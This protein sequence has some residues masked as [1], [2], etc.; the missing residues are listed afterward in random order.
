MAADAFS[1]RRP[2]A[3]LWDVFVAVVATWA[4]YHVPLVLLPDFVPP[5]QVRALEG[6]ITVVFGADLVVQ[7]AR[8]RKSGM[9]SVRDGL[10]LAADAL[11]AIPFTLLGGAPLL[12]LL[13]LLKLGRVAE[14][15]ERLGRGFTGPP[16]VLRLGIFAYWL[17]LTVHL[18]TC[19]F[20][21]LG[22]VNASAESDRYIDALYW[23]VTTLT[24]VGYGDLFPQTQAQ[25]IY[26][27]GVMVLGVGVY[28][29]LIGNIASLLNRIDP[30]RAG[31]LEQRERISAFMRYHALP[32][33]LRNRVLRHLDYRW[34]NRLV[35][36]D[37]AML[38]ALPPSLRDEV[39]RS[40]HQRLLE[41]VP[42][43][44]QAGDAFIRE[45]ALR[46]RPIVCL[47]GD[48][49]V[50]HGER[51]R[52]MYFVSR[53]ELEVLA[54]DGTVLNTLGPGDFFGEI[55]LVDAA[56]R[57]ASVRATTTSDLY[58]LNKTMFER[59][60]DGYPDV[61]AQLQAEAERRR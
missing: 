54:E 13:R 58:V 12:M 16:A 41:S 56:P 23:C 32:R 2:R 5:A 10:G 26:A 29:F 7:A 44:R 15:V 36:Q 14:V 49:V 40:L 27:I 52:E 30:V 38:D 6:A 61:T 47:P 45:V 53:G 24:T 51:G 35:G 31:F 4:S 50:H 37:T 33:P 39:M 34:T 19:G 28:A 20:V 9:R 60:A 8:L 57:T 11:A 25:K 17:G 43:F 55:A 3:D 48:Y 1:E 42:L 22:G 46:L 18:V 59:V 21:A